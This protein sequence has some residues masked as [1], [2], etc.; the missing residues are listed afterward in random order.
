MN[1]EYRPDKV[2]HGNVIHLS[3]SVMEFNEVDSPR[4][5]NNVDGKFVQGV[6]KSIVHSFMLEHKGNDVPAL[7]DEIASWIRVLG[8]VDIFN[9]TFKHYFDEDGEKTAMTVFIYFPDDVG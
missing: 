1:K 5:E 6:R 4:T 9:L 3:E 8:E 2:V 7:L